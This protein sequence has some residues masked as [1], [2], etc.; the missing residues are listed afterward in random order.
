M[1]EQRAGVGDHDEALLLG[2][3]A[4]FGEALEYTELVAREAEGL[5][6]R[7]QQ[8]ER[9]QRGL[10]LRTPPWRG[11]VREA[12]EPELERINV[13]RVLG[14]KLDEL[15]AEQTACYEQEIAAKREKVAQADSLLPGQIGLRCKP[16][17]LATITAKGAREACDTLMA[18]LPERAP[19]E[20]AMLQFDWL[21]T[22][23]AE[24][25]YA[26]NEA[27][28]EPQAELERLRPSIEARERAKLTLSRASGMMHALSEV[29][30]PSVAPKLENA[31][32][33]SMEPLL[34]S[35][36]QHREVLYSRRALAN[37]VFDFLR[38]VR[39]GMRVFERGV[40]FLTHVRSGMQ[41][42]EKWCCCLT[43]FRLFR[44]SP[45]RND[46]VF[47]RN[48][49]NPRRGKISRKRRKCDRPAPNFQK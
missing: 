45:Q 13:R 16:L 1:R 37:A 34:G 32:R 28:A 31:G 15:K 44:D 49:E 25:R 24:Q 19:G 20:E 23:L 38:H 6:V 47:D 11:R 8:L 5:H 17:K 21:P 42:F 46:Q 35:F 33:L 41:V 39:S 36:Y 30:L 18:D 22:S 14:E 4:R 26:T 48:L 3:K 29:E 40:G 27:I 9:R 12:V 43:F 7:R 2:Q 10:R